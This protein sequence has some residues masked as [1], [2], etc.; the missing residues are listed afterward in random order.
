MPLSLTSKVYYLF[1][2]ENFKPILN[3]TADYISVCL[4]GGSGDILSK[5]GADLTD[6]L[7]GLSDAMTGMDSFGE[8]DFSSQVRSS[9]KTLKDTVENY[10]TGKV[11]DFELA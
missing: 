11:L 8:Q 1:I 3:D 4:P 9:W 7:D 6:S 10:H 5:L 2:L